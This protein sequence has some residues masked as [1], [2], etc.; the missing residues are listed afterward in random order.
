[1]AGI[2][3]P[4]SAC[5]STTVQRECGIRQRPAKL[6]ITGD[7][8]ADQQHQTVDWSTE[9]IPMLAQ[10]GPARKIGGVLFSALTRRDG[11]GW[12]LNTRQEMHPDDLESLDPLLDWL[13]ARADYDYRDVQ[14]AEHS[15][16]WGNFVG[17]QRWYEDDTIELRL[18]VENSTIH[19]RA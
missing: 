10:R 7:A 13:G 5:G 14:N 6:T 17:Y 19:R 2:V 3:A 1:L 15:G 11:A 12:A 18:L 8:V 4:P 9:P 16:G